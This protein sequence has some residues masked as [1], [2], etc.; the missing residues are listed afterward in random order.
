ML[1]HAPFG[2][3]VSTTKGVKYFP[4]EGAYQESSRVQYVRDDHHSCRWRFVPVIRIDICSDHAIGTDTSLKRH[5]KT[6]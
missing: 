3:L 5:L 1:L 6:D 4:C 2:L